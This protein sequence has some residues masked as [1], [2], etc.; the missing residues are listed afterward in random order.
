M[1]EI[2]LIASISQLFPIKRDDIQN[3]RA[4][5]QIAATN[6]GKNTFKRYYFLTM[7]P[8]VF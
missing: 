4:M 1:E 2:D 8:N 6:L 5:S 3:Y 7:L